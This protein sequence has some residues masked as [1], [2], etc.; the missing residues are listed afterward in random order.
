[1]NKEFCPLVRRIHTI[2]TSP[3]GETVSVYG[4]EVYTR[5]GFVVFADIDTCA[6]AVDAL[7]DRLR[8][9]RVQLCHLHDIVWDYI[10][11]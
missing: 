11:R 8:C 10:D 6:A 9:E 7:I 4:V 1:M 3:D 2:Y 5:D